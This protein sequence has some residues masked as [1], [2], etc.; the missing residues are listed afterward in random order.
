[1][2]TRETFTIELLAELEETVAVA[3]LQLRNGATFAIVELVHASCS[4]A[5]NAAR[6]SSMRYDAAGK[7]QL[8][9]SRSGHG[10]PCVAL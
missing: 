7:M 3:H 6:Q 1:M 2:A 10:T 8:M 5:T 4:A 9:W